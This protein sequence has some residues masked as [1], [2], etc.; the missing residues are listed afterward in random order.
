MSV[1]KVCQRR[2]SPS[3]NMLVYCDSCDRPYHQFC[4]DPP[5]DREVAIQKNRRWLCTACSKIQEISNNRLDDLVAAG[6]L[7][8]DEVRNVKFSLELACF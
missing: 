8:V 7:T 2:P 1:C 4:H 6:D 5:I 3:G